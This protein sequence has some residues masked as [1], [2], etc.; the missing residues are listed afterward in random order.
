MLSGL[1]LALVFG[2]TLMVWPVGGARAACLEKGRALASRLGARGLAK[3]K[4]RKWTAA[5]TLVNKAI[6]VARK[7]GCQVSRTAANLHVLLGVIR[8]LGLRDRSGAMAAWRQGLVI[9]SAVELPA[10][11]RW[12]AVVRLFKT[13]PRTAGAV[14]PSPPPPPSPSPTPSPPPSPSPSP[15]PPPPEPRTRPPVAS[16][17]RLPGPQPRAR[18]DHGLPRLPPPRPQNEP[19]LVAHRLMPSKTM[20]TDASLYG[21]GSR[22][23]W[24][25]YR[26]EKRRRAWGNGLMLSGIIGQLGF[27]AGSL[28]LLLDPGDQRATNGGWALLTM[29]GLCHIVMWVGVGLRSGADPSKAGLR[30]FTTQRV[31]SARIVPTPTGIVLTGGF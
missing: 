11:F 17:D 12:P 20:P 27:G 1:G 29:T 31:I 10:S 15:P 21:L 26:R 3:G 9:W 24:V 14:R 6:A 5:R 28:A 2:L 25:R 16:V 30:L 22:L 8:L 7:H 13:V 4:A 18:P 23:A 19:P